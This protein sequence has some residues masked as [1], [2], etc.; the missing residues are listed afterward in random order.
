[1]RRKKIIIAHHRAGFEP[2]NSW[3]QIFHC[4]TTAAHVSNSSVVRNLGLSSKQWNLLSA[5]NSP[6]TPN[7][8]SLDFNHRKE[9]DT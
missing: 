4:A 2:A 7:L 6:R 1:M 5:E 8:S 9:E 3:F